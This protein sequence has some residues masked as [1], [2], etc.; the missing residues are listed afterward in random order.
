LRAKL[1]A[2]FLAGLSTVPLARAQE[3][4]VTLYGRVNVDME[5]V[6]GKQ[7]GL[8]CP[9]QCPNPNKFRT[10]SNS[11]M[12]GIRGVESLGEGVSAIFQIENNLLVTQG[13]GT[14]ASRETFL[15]LTGP[16]GTFK[17]GYFLGAYDDILPIFGNV[18]TL[19]TSILSTSALWA[20]GFLGPP[21]AGGFDD[22]LRQSIRYD[23]PR[24]SGF[25]ASFQY[26]SY[27]GLL[28]PHSNAISTGAFY[29]NGPVQLGIAYELHDRIRGTPAEPL[30]DQALSVAGS[31]QFE[32]VRIGA[33]YERLQYEATSTAQLPMSAPD[34]CTRSSDAPETAPAPPSMARA[35][36]A[37]PKGRTRARPNGQSATPTSCRGAR[38]PTPAM[39]RSG[40]IPTPRTRSIRTRI[41]SCATSTP[42][43]NAAG[44]ADSSWGWRTSS[45]PPPRARNLKKLLTC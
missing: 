15:G 7:T 19:T 34:C 2:A 40:T 32:L 11:S 24:M 3:A 12:F 43:G 23:S 27:E 28:R 39:S 37:S 16:L 35:S 45:S 14:L 30:T 13:R 18:P 20:Q 25:N 42:T 41:R 5:V 44:P 26:A 22:R 1:V 9:E 10:N 21:E 38:W 36:A 8:G 4:G 33:V 29:N 17:M 6:N 31:Y